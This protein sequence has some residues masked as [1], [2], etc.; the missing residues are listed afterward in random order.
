MNEGKNE[1]EQKTELS[2]KRYRRKGSKAV[3]ILLK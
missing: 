2:E 1:L 3:S